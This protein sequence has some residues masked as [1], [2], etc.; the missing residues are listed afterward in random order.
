MASIG[1]IAI[2]TA[3]GVQ[4][5]T[6]ALANLNV[7]F[8][9]VRFE[10]KPEFQGVEKRLSKRRKQ[11][12]EDGRIHS[13]ARRLGALFADE[14]P[15]VE[16]LCKLYGL[17]ASEIA[18]NPLA[19]PT[20]SVAHGPVAAHVGVDATSLWAAATS[21][22]GSIQVHLLAC[23]LARQWPGAEAVSIWSELVS[24]RK[25]ELELR[26]QDEMFHRSYVT[27]TRVDIG[28][29]DLAEWDGSAR[30]VGRLQSIWNRVT[31][32]LY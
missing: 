32:F 9:V 14:L 11:Q 8:S 30:A 12:A 18:S 25:A 15:P 5:T 27:L 2:S 10:A 24:S 31:A 6:L 4:E 1:K 21:G 23:M 29:S 26:L 13:T 22:P 16:S 3:T 7:D 19:N 17:R 28:I 20:S